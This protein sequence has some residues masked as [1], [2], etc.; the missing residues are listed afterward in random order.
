[1]WLR[2]SG[3]PDVLRVEQSTIQA[4]PIRKRCVFG[5]PQSALISS[6]PYNDTVHLQSRCPCQVAWEA[7]WPG[8]RSGRLESSRFQ[9]GSLMRTSMM[10]RMFGLSIPMP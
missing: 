3:G 1:M 4:T 6:I 10:V 7:R 5:K 2:E 8:N 9:R